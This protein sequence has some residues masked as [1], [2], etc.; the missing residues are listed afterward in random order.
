MNT[1]S[2][3]VSALQL[4]KSRPSLF[5]SDVWDLLELG[6][7]PEELPSAQKKLYFN[8]IQVAWMKTLIKET[9]WRKRNLVRAATLV[10]YL[11]TIKNFYMF[12][13]CRHENFKIDD[14]NKTLVQS[15]F[16]F[17]S[18]KSISCQKAYI[19]ILNEI[20]T[21]WK[22]WGYLPD[23]TKLISKE[24]KPRTPYQV[25]PRALPVK[26]Q[27]KLEN[28]I[29]SS[30]STTL[31]R[32]ITVLQEVGM[33]ALEALRLKKDCM[34]QDEDGDW[35]LRRINLK[36][37]KEHIVPISSS[38]GNII[39]QQLDETNKI[40]KESGLSN[41]NSY[42]FVHLWR[43]TLREYELRT[44]NNALKKL[45]REL[46]FK[47]D[48]GENE[49]ITS[50]QFRHTVGTNLINRGVSQLH[51]MKFLGHESPQMTMVYAQIH[52]QTLKKAITSAMR[53]IVDIKGNLYNE[54]EIITTMDPNIDR[55]QLLDVKWLKRHISAQAL[56]NGICSLPIKQ[57][58][59]HVNACLTCPSFR[60]DKSFLGV[61][62]DQ[63]G[64]AKLLAAQATK[65]GYLRQNE[66]NQRIVKNLT[67]IIEVLENGK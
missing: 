6:F 51:V 27:N 48:I 28:E 23:N 40:E 59:P 46:S 33:R 41:E 12:A 10:S 8:S 13:Y 3:S 4:I 57:S 32:L 44:L 60:T 64:R 26:T 9:I 56:P 7:S 47:N 67:T 62:K 66:L 49:Q 19:A 2:N 21:C 58:C 14:I 1:K 61:H 38:L 53:T 52:D 30:P 16:M 15:Y 5:D 42:L 22:D 25:K 65:S 63:L 45:S 55:E 39:K 29:T 31:E 36:Y 11:R 17:L 24:D 35:F 50:H 20:F 18:A 37:R 34:S 43:G 54:A